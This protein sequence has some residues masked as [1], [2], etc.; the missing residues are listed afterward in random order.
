MAAS[1]G[2]FV[3]EALEILA[4]ESPS[5]YATIVDLLRECPCRCEF[6]GEGFDV[7]G[8]GGRAHV[9]YEMAGRPRVIVATTS[10]SV[11]RLID[12][13]AMI[14]RLLATEEIRIAGDADGLIALATI[15]EVAIAG[16]LRSLD[17]HELFE[18]FRTHVAAGGNRPKSV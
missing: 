6:A 14:E 5:A 4:G 18:R 17:M 12:G 1:I 13:T 7:H 3:A 8:T 11:V 10:E 16:G 2:S 15:S 9:R